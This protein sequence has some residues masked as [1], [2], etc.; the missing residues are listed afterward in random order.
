MKQFKEFF[1]ERK[2]EDL[3]N[4]VVNIL[5]SNLDPESDDV[6]S[7]KLSEFKD[8]RKLLTDDVI[9]KMVDDSK[10][11]AAILEMIRDGTATISQLISLLT[12]QTT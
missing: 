2:Y 1:S 7:R 10:N 11:R 5:D 8:V 3:R 12:D 9:G 6:L 4:R